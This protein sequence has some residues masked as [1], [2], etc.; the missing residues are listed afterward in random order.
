MPLFFRETYEFQRPVQRRRHRV[1]NSDNCRCTA[2]QTPARNRAWISNSDSAADTGAV[3]LIQRF[4]STANLNIHVHCLVLYGVYQRTEGEPVFQEVRPPIRDELKGLL[5]KIIARPMK[6]LARVGYLVEEQGMTYLADSDVDK[7][8]AS[9]QAA[10]WPCRP[11]RARVARPLARHE[12][13]TGLFVSGLGLSHRL[14]SARRAEGVQLA[15]RGRGRGETQEDPMRPGAWVEPTRRSAAH[16]GAAYRLPLHHPPRDRQ[17]A[18]EP[19]C[20][21]PS[22]VA[23]EK[24]VSRRHDPHSSCTRGNSCNASPRWSH[25]RGLT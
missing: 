16:Q 3:T 10:S 20:E 18:C 25:A 11:R 19:Q 2:T 6:R 4:G 23:T 9:L 8:L 7:P 22:R 24:P 12:R 21:R 14:R 17:R 13:S 5:D 1:K 15:H